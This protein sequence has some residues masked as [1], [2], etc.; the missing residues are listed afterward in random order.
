WSPCCRRETSR[1]HW[2]Q[3]PICRKASMP[4]STRS[5]LTWTTKRCATTGCN[6]YTGCVRCSCALPT[7]RCCNMSEA[8]NAR[9]IILD[10]DGVIIED[11]DDYIKSLDEWRPL[12]GSIE[13]IAALSRA[14]FRIAVATNQSGI[15]RGYFDEVTLAHMH[16]L[17]SE[18]VEAAG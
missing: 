15:G 13:A 6:C 5:W 17:L 12:P 3:W 16:S 14:G 7:S 9:L 11:S 2:L 8:S 1:R 18:L 4:S 10:R